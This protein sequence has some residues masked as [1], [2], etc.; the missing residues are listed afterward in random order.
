[1]D[2]ILPDL[3]ESPSSILT[4]LQAIVDNDIIPELSITQ[5]EK[6]AETINFLHQH[7]SFKLLLDFL[8]QLPPLSKPSWEIF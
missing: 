4:E 3:P 6:V 5:H 1:G 8:L 2:T 7:Y